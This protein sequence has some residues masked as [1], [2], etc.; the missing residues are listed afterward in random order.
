MTTKTLRALIAS[1]PRDPKLNGPNDRFIWPL[2]ASIIFA[3]TEVEEELD[4]L[5][6]RDPTELHIPQPNVQKIQ[7]C[8]LL[9]VCEW[10]GVPCFDDAAPV[11]EQINTFD[12]FDW[13]K[14]KL[15]RLTDEE[16][17]ALE[18]GHRVLAREWDSLRR[19][20]LG[21]A[22]EEEAKKD[23]TWFITLTD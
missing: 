4:A 7:D 5:G 18:I 3:D 9:L 17:S 10:S 1:P 22:S 8:V 20:E 23:R 12:R 13:E 19:I 16:R 2:G 11:E 14:G 15:R 21:E 6:E